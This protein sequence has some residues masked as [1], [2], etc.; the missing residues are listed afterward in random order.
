MIPRR[1]STKLIPAQIKYPE[2]LWIHFHN[3]SHSKSTFKIDFIITQIY[4]FQ[5]TTFIVEKQ[6]FKLQ[7]HFI[8]QII[9]RQLYLLQTVIPSLNQYVDHFDYLFII[10]LVVAQIQAPY[11][12]IIII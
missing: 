2:V 1:T 5:Y 7:C 8:T 12:L 9:F 11:I 4:I 6:F 10:E 3:V